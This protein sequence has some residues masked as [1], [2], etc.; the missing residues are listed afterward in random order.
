MDSGI[1]EWYELQAALLNIDPKFT[2]TDKEDNE[3]ES[4]E[5]DKE[6]IGR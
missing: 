2:L 6:E 4:S 5:T 3:E 1:T